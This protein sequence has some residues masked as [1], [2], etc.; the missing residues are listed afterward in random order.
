MDR[1]MRVDVEPVVPGQNPVAYCMERH[2][3]ILAKLV[4]GEQ[5]D[6]DYARAA[7]RTG[8]VDVAVLHSRTGDLPVMRRS[9]SK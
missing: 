2:D 5:R 1:L 4:R 7:A 3:M 8:L 6:V 9:G